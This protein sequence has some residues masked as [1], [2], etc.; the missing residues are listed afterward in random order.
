[1]SG[2]GQSRTEKNGGGL[3]VID[4]T[5]ASMFF[6][7]TYYSAGEIAPVGHASAHVPQSTQTLGS[8]L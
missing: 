1:M 2:W 8:I 6:Y 4:F 3:K 7:S 5:A